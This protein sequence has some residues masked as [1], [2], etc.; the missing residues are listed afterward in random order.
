MTDGHR[1]R[2][3]TVRSPA[4]WWVRLIRRPIHHSTSVEHVDWSPYPYC[5]CVRHGATMADGP[6]WTMSTLS[7]LH[8]WTGLTLFYKTWKGADDDPGD[9]SARGKPDCG[10]SD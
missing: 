3:V 8:R 2:M 1:H 4:L 7:F 10:T 6:C 9:A 5:P